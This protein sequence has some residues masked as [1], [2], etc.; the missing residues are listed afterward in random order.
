M[1]AIYLT[2]C[3]A[4]LLLGA[5]SHYSDDLAS[6]EGKMK[7]PAQP[8]ALAAAPQDIAPA[9]G[10]T[11][12]LNATLAS[13]YYEMAR[14]ENDKAYD[15]KAAKNFTHKAK[16]AAEGK[17]VVPSKVSDF[18]VPEE[19]QA[20]LN[21]ARTALIN[22]LKTQNTP[23]NQ[24]TLG[25]AQCRYECWLERAEEAADSAHYTQCKNEFEQAMAMLVAPAAGAPEAVSSAYDIQFAQN[26]TVLSEAAQKDIP[27]I[28][29]ILA[30]PGNENYTATI[31]GYTG[32][33]QGEYAQSLASTRVE[34]VRKALAAQGVDVSR[35]SP[36]ISSDVAAASSGPRVQVVLVPS[37]TI[38]SSNVTTKTEFVPVNP[39][40]APVTT[41][42]IAPKATPSTL[43]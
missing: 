6:M 24:Q 28:A 20:E 15:Y 2:S 23:E 35:V 8:A 27:M 13:Q 9:A 33:A 12:T 37:A 41:P 22:A 4:V 30:A 31:T 34:S 5:C 21:A 19:K 38:P 26:S 3:A 17:R 14:H 29:G 10:S 11:D 36:V 16:M 43:N 40:P 18:D 32:T 7:T 42:V 25:T 39:Q 1:K